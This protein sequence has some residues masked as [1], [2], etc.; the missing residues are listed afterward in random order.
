MIGFRSYSDQKIIEEIRNGNEEMLVYVY[1]QNYTPVRNFILRN[2]GDEEEID[3][4][5][6]D[7][8]IALWQNVMKDDFILTARLSTYLL[9]IVKNLWFKR[10]K[11]KHRLLRIDESGIEREKADSEASKAIEHID[12]SAIHDILAEMD[13][14]CKKLLC[15]F[16]FDG[17]NN[18]VIAEKLGFANTDTVKSKK[19]QCFKKLESRVKEVYKKE[20]FFN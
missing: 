17:F 16:Y 8:V 2:S 19:Y 14:T 10:L 6:Q 3:D 11:K 12:L 9:A 5:L 7:G 18:K 20:D 4:V 15:Y 13:E 1:K